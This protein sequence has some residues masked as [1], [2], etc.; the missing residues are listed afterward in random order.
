MSMQP[1]LK[2]AS[3]VNAPLFYS[4]VLLLLDRTYPKLTKSFGSDRSSSSSS[5]VNISCIGL[6]GEK[7][8]LP[9]L[10]ITFSISLHNFL[11]FYI[12]LGLGATVVKKEASILYLFVT[13]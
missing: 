10:V 2:Y 6:R 7:G 9:T 4:G 11:I 5:L 8:Q 13:R 3:P 1:T 12:L